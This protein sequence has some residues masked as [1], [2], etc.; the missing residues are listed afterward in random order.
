MTI[1]KFQQT[2]LPLEGVRVTEVSQETIYPTFE[3]FHNECF[4]ITDY[5]IP[6]SYYDFKEY[7]EEG[8][9]PE[10]ALNEFFL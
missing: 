1:T 9:T 8:L 4:R 5:Q 6:L 10:Q 2:A 3:A 7:F